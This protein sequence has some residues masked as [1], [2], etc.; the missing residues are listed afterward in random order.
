[1]SERAYGG[2]EIE[3]YRMKAIFYPN[4]R[5]FFTTLLCLLLG[6]ASF[7]V[8]SKV[9][10]HDSSSDMLKGEMEKVVI[11]SRGTIQL[12]RAAK[13]LIDEQEDF[14]DVWSINSIVVS[15]GTVYFGTSPNGGIYK[16]SLNK[17]TKIYPAEDTKSTEVSNN[18]ETTS[19][20][21]DDIIEAEKHLSNE[22]IF[23]MTTDL[24]GRLLVG[25]S[26]EKCRLCRFEADKMEI[27]FEPNDA[28]YIFAIA[29]DNTGDIYLGTGPEGKIYRLDPLGKKSQLAYDSRDKN[30]LSLAVGPDGS[31]Y[32]GSDNRG[33]IYMINPRGEGAKVLYD[34]EQPEIAA[35]LFS[36]QSGKDNGTNGKNSSE[37]NNSLYAAATS[38]KIVQ[39]QTQFAASIPAGPPPGRPEIQDDQEDQEDQEE[40]NND[41]NDNGDQEEEPDVNSGGGGRKLEIANTKQSTPGKSAQPI[42]PI[43]RSTRPSSASYIYKVTQDGFVTEIFKESAVF[44]CLGQQDNKLFVGTGNKAQLYSVDPASEQQAVIYED[45]QAVQITAI[46]VS[47]DDV[48][49]GTA[50]PAKLIKLGSGFAQEGTYISD[51]IDAEQPAKWGKLQLEADIPADCK[52]L[53]ASRSGNIEDINDPTFS[54][55]TELV[56]VTEPVQLQ[57]PLGR[58][59]QY[60]LV[61]QSENGGQSPLIREIAVASTVPNLAPQIESVTMDRLR[62]SSKKGT[63][64]ISY[65]ATDENKDD[66]IYKIDFR[67][68]GRTTWIELKDNLEAT[69]FEW[70]GKTVEDGRYEVRVTA[71]DERSNTTTTK[72]TGSR[73]SDPIVVDNTGPI[74]VET[75]MTS[76]SR[77]NQ[78]YMVFDTEIMDQLSA[79]E[80][81]EYTIDS[82]SDWIATVPND[83]VYDTTKEQFTI[84]IETEKDLSKGD[85]ILTIKASDAVGNTTYKTYDINVD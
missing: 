56:E 65:R 28:K 44:F 75:K 85:H 13:L 14:S 74:A 4:Y 34:S 15:G 6:T 54:P 38:A 83:L 49:L 68:L 9:T 51:L 45:E 12:G 5:M 70:D 26:G 17:I 66:L 16:Y 81:L 63:F 69:S 37:T 76:M 10:R 57:C 60:K 80:K 47:G 79:I 19:D 30:I 61:L 77:N 18:E 29:V 7:A 32:A 3:S 25:I 52:V 23:A 2:M 27:I 71:S 67:K 43:R 82:N 24:A 36:L 53:V 73:I 64:K 41:D 84:K 20:E 50:N 8:N 31:I 48:Y 35:L 40:D 72:L 62:T 1:M 33:L 42:P 59:C 55:W 22:H 78:R 21:S 46:A 58:F 39:T 11:G